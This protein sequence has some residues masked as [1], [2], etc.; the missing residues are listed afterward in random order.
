MS[1][2]A[3]SP[4]PIYNDYLE[5]QVREDTHQWVPKQPGDSRSPCP[6]LNT[7]ANHGYL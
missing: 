7:L 3:T 6:A 5:D 1:T 2:P 4:D